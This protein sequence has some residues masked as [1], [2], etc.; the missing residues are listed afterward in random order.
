MNEGDLFAILIGGDPF[1]L[2]RTLWKT[3]L[4]NRLKTGTCDDCW[5]GATDG[6]AYNAYNA[7]LLPP[8]TASKNFPFFQ[9]ASSSRMS[10]LQCY[11]LPER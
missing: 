4:R 11:E 7:M 6:A 1:R 8:A 9:A 2:M 10:R 3:K 5:K